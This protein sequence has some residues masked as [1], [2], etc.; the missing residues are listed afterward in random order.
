MSCAL[1]AMVRAAG[2][3]TDLENVAYHFHLFYIGLL[4]VS[5]VFASVSLACRSKVREYSF[6]SLAL[7][8][9]S[10]RTC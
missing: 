7:C 8:F 1:C 10:H 5:C 2:R 6:V 4:L 3:E 9:Y